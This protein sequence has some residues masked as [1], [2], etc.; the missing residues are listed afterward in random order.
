MRE[1]VQ[2]LTGVD[3]RYDANILSVRERVSIYCEIVQENA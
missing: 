1:K 2:E 3:P